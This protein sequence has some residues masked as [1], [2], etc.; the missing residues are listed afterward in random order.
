MADLGFVEVHSEN[1]FDMGGQPMAVLERARDLYPLSLHGI[2]LSLGS[3][4]PLDRRH[5]RQLKAL[6]DH[7]DPWIVSDHLAWVGLDG[8]Y[9]NDLLPVPLTAEALRHIVDHVDEVQQLL[10]RRLLIE[11]PSTYLSFAASSIAEPDFLALVVDQTQC[12]LLLDINNVYVSAHNH[13]FDAGEYL[14][15]IPA[16][17]VAE[18]HLAGHTDTGDI[19]IDTHDRRVIEPVWKLYR[20]ALDRFGDVPT[21]IEWDAALPPLATLID[22]ARLADAIRSDVSHSGVQHVLA[23]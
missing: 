2:G 6:V 13:G 19:L 20:Q 17:S 12:G 9:S 18:I 7:I 14:A 8:V 15:R 21:L 16:A 3:A 23:A 4:E 10:G 22:E 5:L 1:F 11:N